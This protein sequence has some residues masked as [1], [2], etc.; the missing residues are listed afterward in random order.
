MSEP[1]GFSLPADA[2]KRALHK[3]LPYVAAGIV[4]PSLIWHRGS[5]ATEFETIAFVCVVF[6]SAY[7][8]SRHYKW[9]YLSSDGLRGKNPWGLN[10]RSSSVS[11]N[12]PVSIKRRP[13]QNLQGFEILAEEGKKSIFLPESIASSSEFVAALRAVAPEGHPLHAVVQGVGGGA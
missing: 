10:P 1:K 6:A 8:Y 2:A 5:I 13:Y 3:F 4:L 7:I 9:V 12:E 11:W